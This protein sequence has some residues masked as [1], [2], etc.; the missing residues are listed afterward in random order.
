MTRIS[1]IRGSTGV[2]AGA[3]VGSSTVGIAVSSLGS[4]AVSS[5]VAVVAELSELPETGASLSCHS[6]TGPVCSSAKVVV[7]RLRAKTAAHNPVVS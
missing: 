6:V 2:S 4:G 1:E 7:A 5:F 3:G